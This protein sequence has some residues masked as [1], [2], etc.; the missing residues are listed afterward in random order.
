M[1]NLKIFCFE[2]Y[3]DDI[4]NNI[5]KDH[6][7]PGVVAHACNSGTWEAEAVLYGV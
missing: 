5:N 7:M 4:L 1:Y 3:K 6:I 2:N